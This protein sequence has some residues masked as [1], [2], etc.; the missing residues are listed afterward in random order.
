MILIAAVAL[1]VLAAFALFNYVRGIEDSASQDAE[2]VTV[3]KIV[4]DVPEGTPGEV[5]REEGLIEEDEVAREFLPATSISSLD[6]LE[7]QVAMTNLAANQVLVQGMFVDPAEAQTGFSQRLEGDDVA[8]TVQV[9]QVS[10]V[11]G[12]LVPG[13][14]VDVFTFPPDEAAAADVYPSAARLLYHQ[15]EVLAVGQTFTPTPGEAPPT[16]AAPAEGEAAPAEAA[17]A[18]T[19]DATGLITFVVPPEAA[20]R[21]VSVS[22]AESGIFLAL[23][24]PDYTARPLPALEDQ[25]L[26]GEES[27]QLTPYGPNGREDT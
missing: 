4:E 15:V 9:D 5:A 26:P 17:P 25:T 27:G 14:L 12:L 10:G 21:I 7:G 23:T 1:G 2:Q 11:A 16:G 20:Q 3:Y 19:A 18:A 6:E 8:I 13:D 22:R 24:G